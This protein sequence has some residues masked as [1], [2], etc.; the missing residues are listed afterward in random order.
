VVVIEPSLAAVRDGLRLLHSQGGLAEARQPVLVLNRAGRPGGL[1]GSDL[2]EALRQTPDVS[3]P[4][5]P[6]PIGQAA[7]MGEVAASRPGPFRQALVR[8]AAE[9]AAIAREAPPKR[10]LLGRL[11]L[12]A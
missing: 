11:G 3:F 2:A 9:T 1:S 12:G 8:L 7:T 4:D 5:L 10:G 6:K